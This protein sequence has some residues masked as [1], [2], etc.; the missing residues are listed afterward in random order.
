V[1]EKRLPQNLL[2]AT[3]YFA[4]PDTC[5]EF[6]ASLRW[7]DGPVCPKCGGTEHSY[8]TTR[9]LWK[10]KNKECHKQFSVKVGTIFED[11]PIPLDKWLCSI[12]LIANAKNGISSHELGR[13]VGLT[14][15]SAWFVLH[16][17]RLAMQVGNFDKFDGEVETDETFVGG[18]GTFMH[19]DKKDRVIQGPG[20]WGHKTVVVGT[21]QRQAGAETSRV[22][23]QVVPARTRE[24]L[25]GHVRDTVE[26]GSALYTDMHEAY[27]AL[28]DEYDHATV[29]HMREYVNGRVH[30][31]G[32]ENFWTLLKRGL[33]GTYVYADPAHLFR[34][35]DER[36]F[37]FNERWQTDLG[38]SA[39]VV[40]A[41]SG[42]RLTYAEL[43][44]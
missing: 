37:T 17:I 26:P 39:T 33:K 44:S 4:D 14:Q 38:R 23:A 42:R 32:I 31:Q 10:C 36:V 15:K 41:V 20:G 29:D 1:S 28:G 35:V 22:R 25:R 6:V 3:R 27:Q 13:S 34:Y 7:P 8:L 24:H 16:R 9:R 43:T 19:K 40:A 11:S 2:E 21:I 12:W 30:T 18:A 5:V